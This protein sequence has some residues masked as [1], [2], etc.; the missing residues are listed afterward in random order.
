MEIKV[1]K[2]LTAGVL[3][4]FGFC[5]G[6]FMAPKLANS[7]G[8]Q[9]IAGSSKYLGFFLVC[10]G[11]YEFIPGYGSG[12]DITDCHRIDSYTSGGKTYHSAVITMEKK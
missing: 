12:M 11:S 3:V 5:L 10:S 6:F 7:S 9:C 1:R 8:G 4:A 2:M